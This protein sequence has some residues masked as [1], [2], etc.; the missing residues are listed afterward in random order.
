MSYVTLG[1][2]RRETAGL[3]DE[4]P[5]YLST[6]QG[7]S[8]RRNGEEPELPSANLQYRA[9]DVRLHTPPGRRRAWLQITLRPYVSPAERLGL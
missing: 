7:A 2:L 6:N 8:R 4:T 5:I 9:I 1:E 3:P